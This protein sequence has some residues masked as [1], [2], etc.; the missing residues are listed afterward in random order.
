MGNKPARKV[1]INK[2]RF[3]EV[4]KQRNCSIRKLGEAYEEIERTEKTIRR[5]LDI[6]EMPPDLL[7]KI[8]KY[9]DVHPDYLSGVYDD[10]ADHIEDAFLRAMSKSFIKPEKYPYLLKAKSDIGYT[11]YF[12][13]IL[14]MNDISMDLFHTLPPEERVLFRQE[15]VV[16]IMQVI[17]K[18][19][20][21]DSLGIDTAETLAYCESYVGDFD[22]FSY[23]SE[24]E[25]INLP[26]PDFDD[27]FYDEDVMRDFEKRMKVKYGK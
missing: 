21:H 13:N 2:D 4:L 7:N 15:M 23:Y 8:A 6:G 22:P 19:F 10:K 27:G 17:A 14:T 5:C 16:A 24:L 26:E 12:E 3:M 9:L 25:G 11:T 1:T 20:T 18:H